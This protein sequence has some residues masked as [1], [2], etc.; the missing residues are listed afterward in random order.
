MPK[1]NKPILVCFVVRLQKLQ[2]FKSFIVLKGKLQ[3][4]PFMFMITRGLVCTTGGLTIGAGP[5]IRLFS[6]Q[7]TRGSESNTAY[8]IPP[9]MTV[10]TLNHLHVQMFFINFMAHCYLLKCLWVDKMEDT[11]VLLCRR[12]NQLVT[13]VLAKRTQEFLF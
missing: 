8:I 4:G 5:L 3:M 1:T 12:V 13:C 2:S 10:A 7:A 6:V 11:R 9:V